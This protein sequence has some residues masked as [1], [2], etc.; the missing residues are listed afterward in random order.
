MK[1]NLKN[2]A[3]DTTV[4]IEGVWHE[5][6]AGFRVKVARMNNPEYVRVFNRL[7][8]PYRQAA[9]AGTL[10]E[11]KKAMLAAE[12]IARTILLNWESLYIDDEEIPYSIE[13]A[14]EILRDPQYSPFFTLV[15]QFAQE[16]ETFRQQEIE[17]ELEESP[18]A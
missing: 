3:V 13:K 16:N 14:Q 2:L 18:S 7:S 12:A 1:F 11:E 4:E 9:V 5:V 8:A 6:D 15:M 17:T 10:S